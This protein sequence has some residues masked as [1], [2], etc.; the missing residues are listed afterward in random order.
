MKRVL[1]TSGGGYLAIGISRALKA[2]PEP[3]HIIGTDSSRYHLHQADAD[4]LHLIPRAD[5]P[6]FVEVLAEVAAESNADFIWPMHDAEIDVISSVANELPAKTWLPPS[7]VIQLGR[8]KMATFR[9]LRAAG[10][11]VPES[12]FVN[13]RDD[14]K[15]ALGRFGEVWLRA[16]SGAGAN[17]AFRASNIEHATAWLDINN[18]WGKFMA[19]EVLPGPFDHSWEGIWK[20]GEL[21]VSQ[22]MTRLVRGSTGI[23]IPGVRSRTVSKSDAPPGVHPAAEQ[24]VR[25][26]MQRPDGIFRVDLLA[27]ASGASCVT[28]VD[29]GR[30]GAGGMAYWHEYGYNFPHIAL[31]LGFGEPVEFETPVINPFSKDLV[32]IQGI[33]RD[34]VLLRMGEIEDTDRELEERLSRRG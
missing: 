28:E 6:K 1:I 7:E 3:I 15:E 17:G 27:N 11:P 8:D 30:L 2:A 9:R 5:H 31:K 16:N 33:N 4:E 34:V 29:A 24:A 12:M 19:A 23:S 14:I 26:M 20:D 13:S 25:A 22:V 10:V 21:I 32:K 18:G